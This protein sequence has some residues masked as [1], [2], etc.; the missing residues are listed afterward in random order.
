MSNA[1]NDSD[2][3]T[4]IPQ[5]RR[6][7]HWLTYNRYT[8]FTY[9]GG[10]FFP[11][12][13]ILLCLILLAI[14][15]TPYMLFVLY[16]NRKH[17]WLLLFAIIVGIPILPAFLSTGNFVLNVMM[18]FLPLLAFYL[19]CFLLRFSVDDWISD[20][21]ETHQLWTEEEDRQSKLGQ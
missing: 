10:I 7:R 16:K 18:H 8:I 9:G 14:L 1:I 4:N 17:G 13:I 6:L 2:P 11:A 5:L 3:E 19:Y 20:T 15:F 12:G 21:S